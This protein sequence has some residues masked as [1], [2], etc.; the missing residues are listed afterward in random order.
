MQAM[1]VSSTVADQRQ[2]RGSDPPLPGGVFYHRHC[3]EL[4]HMVLLRSRQTCSWFY[5][6]FKF[7]EDNEPP[8]SLHPLSAPCIPGSRTASAQWD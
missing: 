1:W 5:Y 8:Y 3:L 6:C 2:G 4:W 7:S